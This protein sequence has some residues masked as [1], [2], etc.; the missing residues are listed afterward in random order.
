LNVFFDN[1]NISSS[2]G[3]NGFAKKLLAELKKNHEIFTSVYALSEK[4]ARPDIQISFIAAQNNIAPIVQRL[5]GIYFN[6][7]QD[8]MSM[9]TPILETYQQASAVICQS[10]FNKKLTKHW[11]GEHDN[12]HI[13]NNGTC[14]EKIASIPALDNKKINSFDN[15]WSCASSWR[16]HKRLSENVRYFLEHSNKNDCLVIAGE[17]PDHAVSHPRIFYANHLEWR[18]LI[19]LFKKSKYFIHLSWLDHCPN[20]VIDARA[21]GCEIIC[22]S[23]GGTKEIAGKNAT[24]IEEDEWDFSPIKLYSP[25]NMDFSRSAKNTYSSD[26]SIQS[27][28]KKY[29]SVLSEVL[30][31]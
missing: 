9:N 16:P 30:N 17:N 2:S 15:V 18:D 4:G 28:S 5:D 19:S 21:A 3:P 27:V 8:Y 11:F 20:V 10:S 23:S 7:D 13:I 31:S 1:V 14:F 24:I 26:I 12:C 6:S 25:P 29:E 22:S